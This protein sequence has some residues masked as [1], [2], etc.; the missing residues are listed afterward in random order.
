MKALD[1]KC[2]RCHVI[3]TMMC[4]AIEVLFVFINSKRWVL[5]PRKKGLLE[6]VDIMSGI[7]SVQEH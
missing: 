3:I 6:H 2:K 7:S 1:T 4:E 5:R